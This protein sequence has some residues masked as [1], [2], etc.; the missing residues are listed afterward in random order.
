MVE[1]GEG[2]REV[3]LSSSAEEHL[4]DIEYEKN[5]EN[6][7]RDSIKK[8]EIKGKIRK[9]RRDRSGGES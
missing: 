2:T 7:I 1:N 8:K 6:G 4:Q 9:Y 3:V 5:Y